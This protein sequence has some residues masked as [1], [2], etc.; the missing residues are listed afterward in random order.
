MNWDYLQ[1]I[2]LL[3]LALY[4]FYISY[5]YAAPTF[6][7]KLMLFYAH[8]RYRDIDILFR[9]EK[10]TIKL[11][12]CGEEHV[13]ERKLEF[14][15]VLRYFAMDVCNVFKGMLRDIRKGNFNEEVG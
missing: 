6:F 11:T 2:P 7:L 4:V 13:L 14:E 5:Y 9:D 12:K 15:P 1:L 3:A 10:I 8:L